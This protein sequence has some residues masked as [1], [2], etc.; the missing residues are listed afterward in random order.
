M[1]RSRGELSGEASR[2]KAVQA[3][4]E[5]FATSGYQ[6]TSIARV[7]EKTGLSQSGLL[8]HFPSKTALLSAVLAERDAEDSKFV[9]GQ[10]EP[11]GWSAFDALTALVA[12]NAA[13]PQLVGLFVRVT[14]E[15]TE[16]GHPAHE[17]VREHYAGIE[18][19]LTEAVRAGQESGEIRADAPVGTLVHT[20]I[21]VLDGLQQ[22]WLLDPE[23]ISMTDEFRAYVDL[24]RARWG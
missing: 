5:L 4:V 3:A 12:R 17:W 23:R 21:A 9:A 6:G 22:Q 11:V 13:R 2:A 16:P 14:A 8:H 15:G 20:T 24:L 10:G 19:F 1:A 18:R 7:A